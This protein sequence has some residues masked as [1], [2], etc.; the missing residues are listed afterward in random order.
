VRTAEPVGV[1]FHP[2]LERRCSAGCWSGKRSTRCK[3]GRRR[4]E[5]GWSLARKKGRCISGYRV[6]DLS[7]LRRSPPR[8]RACA[9]RAASAVLRCAHASGSAVARGAAPKSKGKV[10]AIWRV[11][12]S[13][14]RPSLPHSTRL[15]S[16]KAAS[17]LPVRRSS[18]SS[19]RSEWQKLTARQHDRRLRLQ[20]RRSRHKYVRELWGDATLQVHGEPRHECKAA[21]AWCPRIEG[22]KGRS[23]ESKS[24]KVT[25]KRG[26][27][28][29][30]QE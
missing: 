5:G 30:Y 18:S 22:A 6:H 11:R 10:A 8:G 12:G 2:Q 24:G 9:P 25:R 13:P 4:G 26:G 3:G 29:R 20:L 17:S 15:A 14:F 1:G 27:V 21:S 16:G 23:R 19:F 7:S 28:K